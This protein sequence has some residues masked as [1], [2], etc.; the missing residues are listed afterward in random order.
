MGGSFDNRTLKVPFAGSTSIERHYSQAGQDLF[1]AS[2]LNGKRNGIFLDLGCNGPIE[3]NNT[4]LLES[5]F[6]WNGLFVDIDERHFQLYVFRKS[7][8]LTADCTALDWDKVIENLGT[9]SIDYLSLDLEPP[10]LTLQCLMSIP[11]DRVSFSVITFEHDAYRVGE[12]V[13]VPS[14][15]I[16][17]NAGYARTCSD[18]SLNGC[19]FEDWYCDPD[20]VD[21]DRIEALKSSDK[22]WEKIVFI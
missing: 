22:E 15:E 6:D 19:V 14:R 21:S 12:A 4:Y 1:V 2:L 10:E 18:V 11:F 20:A 8:T 9:R 5:E 7:K 17:E 16:F 3:I 13:R